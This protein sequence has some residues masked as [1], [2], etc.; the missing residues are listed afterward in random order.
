MRRFALLGLALTLVFISLCPAQ[1]TTE[2]YFQRISTEH[3]LPQSSVQCV[4]QDRLGFVWLGTRDGLARY[5]GYRFTVFRHDPQDATTLSNSDIRALLE[6]KSSGTIWIGTRDG[7]L[8]R[9]DRA[10]GKFTRYEHRSDVSTSL[11]HNDVRAIIEDKAGTL[12]VGTCGGGLNRFDRT[13][14]TFKHYVNNSA[15]TKNPG[16]NKILSLLEDSFGR[17]WVGTA[18]GL[19]HFDY[20]TESFTLYQH[21]PANPTSLSNNN[22]WSLLQDR[23]GVLWV[24][25][26]GGGLNRFDRQT[27]KFVR[28]QYAPSDPT[29]LSNN[30]VLSLSTDR[31]SSNGAIWV[32]TYGGGVNYLDPTTGKFIRYQ[33]NPADANSLSSNGVFALT[34]DRAGALWVGTDAGGVTRFDRSAVKFKRFQHNPDNTNSL[35]NNNVVSLLEDRAGLLWVGTYGGGVS[36]LDPATGKFTQYKNNPANPT[37]LSDDRVRSFLEERHDRNDGNKQQG[38]SASVLWVGTWG[39]LNRFNRSTHT[40][41]S[42]KH[43]PTDPLSLSHNRVLSLL[44]DRTGA[45]WA[46]TDEGLDKFDKPTGTFMHYKHSSADTTTLSNNAVNMLLEDHKVENNKD[47]T[48]SVKIWVGTVGG[49]LNCFD[50]TTGKFKR[51]EH[52][53][54]NRTSLSHNRVLSLLEDHS[55]TLWV[56]TAGGLNR[57]ERSSET[58]TIFREKDGLPNDVINGMAEDRHGNLWISTNK[59]LCKFDTREQTFITYDKRDGL[60][61]NEFNQGAYHQGMSGH[62]YFGGIGG[63][64]AFIPD[65]VRPDS[66][67]PPIVITTFNKF[68]RSAALDTAIEV[69]TLIT[70]PYNDN[71]I[72]FEFVT[73]SFSIMERNLYRHK[74]ESF[75]K[76]WSPASAERKATYTNLDPGEYTFRVRGC[77]SDG[78]W[79]MQG[80]SVRIVILPPWWS[81]WWSRTAFILC[82]VGILYQCYR[83]R[84]RALARQNERLEKQVQERTAQLNVA[85]RELGD[86]NEEISRQMDI[87]AE[88]AREV[89]LANTELHEK[90]A[91]LD[92][93]IGNLKNTQAQLIHSE[94]MA[95]IGQL[96]AGVMHE[97]NN[98]NAAI[99][100]AA[101]SMSVSLRDIEA[102]FFSL[103]DARSKES[104]KA[105]RF[106][107]MLEEARA[108]NDIAQT[109]SERIMGIV[110]ELQHFTKHQRVGAGT[111]SVAQEIATT[112]EMFHYQF[113][114]AVMTDVTPSDLQAETDWG[115]LNQA[116]LSILVNAAQADAKT[117]RLSAHTKDEAGR[118]VLI[119]TVED[120]G[121]G[122]PEETRQRIFEPFFTTKPVTRQGAGL[123][124]TI[125][126]T[127]LQKNGGRI[128]VESVEH[129]GTTVVIELPMVVSP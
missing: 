64:N 115:E 96:T 38:A 101:H 91:A 49:G 2:A 93:A 34:E 3:G 40:F 27:G 24:G 126:R 73:L 17:L 37:S 41:K 10:T 52:K 112:V 81:R 14:G 109:G 104:Q 85:N 69:K 21:N 84:T 120:D 45:I 127:I 33:H 60:Q 7:G 47:S 43:N 50:P 48:Q 65:S 119:I 6:D 53:P 100:A 67:P 89:E 77:N 99:Y 55:G 44:Q 54:A 39:G 35:S 8:N 70:L 122:M 128:D 1:P 46:G 57:F 105:K 11:S 12:W 98:P 82:F 124:M 123:G 80:A 51:Y 36:C 71:D 61:D 18:H 110:G 28:Y 95:A 72:G 78:T 74:L 25:T 88:Q 111:E 22:V 16:D 107:Q 4:L 97:I 23:A 94:K 125:A 5:D 103:L 20:T 59:G 66:A 58:F 62:L 19:H 114:T 56:G 26:Y 117:I 30:N 9:F 106:S 113:S 102:Y 31:K 76:D 87:Q 116:L 118:T 75:D 32:G 83:W 42:Y 29:S 63:F 13:T 86:A 68:N 108:I 79:N 15:D 92:T 90:N 129:I 121:R